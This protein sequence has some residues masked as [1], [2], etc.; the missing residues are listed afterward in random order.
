MRV[1]TTS[2]LAR[3]NGAMSLLVRG[4]LEGAPGSDENDDREGEFKDDRFSITL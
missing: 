1:D 4:E 2:V 3:Y